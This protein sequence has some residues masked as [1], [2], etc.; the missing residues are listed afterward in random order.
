M[1]LITARQ[2]WHDA[3]YNRGNSTLARIEEQGKLGQA[4][5]RNTYFDSNQR[6]AHIV[7]AGQVQHAIASLPESLQQ[8]GHWLYSPLTTEQANLIVDEVQ[9]NV[10]TQAQVDHEDNTV[11]WLTIAV[12]ADYQDIVLGREQ[13]LKTPARIRKYLAEWHSVEINTRRWA[14]EWQPTWQALWNSISDLDAQALKPVAKLVYQY[15]QAA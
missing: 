4:I 13:R 11:Y 9:D 1:R 10:F 6:A 5:Q 3:F 2:A 12:M 15:K 7:Q 14:R 8:L